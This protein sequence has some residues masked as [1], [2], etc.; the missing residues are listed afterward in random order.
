L[1]KLEGNLKEEL[2]QKN[3]DLIDYLKSILNYLDI[4]DPHYQNQLK[5]AEKLIKEDRFS[6]MD[7]EA[8]NDKFRA[9]F[10]LLTSEDLKKLYE[11]LS[12]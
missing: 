6:T 1:E 4:D 9:M 11:D 8:F 7:Y 12:N 3:R 2:N 10:P 5:N